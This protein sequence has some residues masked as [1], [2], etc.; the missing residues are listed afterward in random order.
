MIYTI[1]FSSTKTPNNTHHNG[2]TKH[3]FGEK[4]K[5]AQKKKL[6]PF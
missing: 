6:V 1:V 4:K 3:N 5:K 2:K